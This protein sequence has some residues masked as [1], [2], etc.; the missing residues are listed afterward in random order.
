MEAGEGDGGAEAVMGTEIDGTDGLGT[1]AQYL[2]GAHGT[3]AEMLYVREQVP[4]QVADDHTHRLFGHPV[5]LSVQ[6]RSHIKPHLSLFAVMR[7]PLCWMTTRA[8]R[9]RKHTAAK[10][11]HETVKGPSARFAWR[12]AVSGPTPK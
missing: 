5:A 6:V 8:S 12:A 3:R 1:L 2:Y 9:L 10:L 4:R 7:C 11:S